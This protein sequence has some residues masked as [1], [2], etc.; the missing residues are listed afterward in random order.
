MVHAVELGGSNISAYTKLKLRTKICGR[1]LMR[2]SVVIV[3]VLA[4]LSLAVMMSLIVSINVIKTEIEVC[5]F[6]QEKTTT[7]TPQPT[8]TARQP[9]TSTTAQSTVDSTTKAHGPYKKPQSTTE[10]EH[11]TGQTQQPT[12]TTARM[13][14]TEAA[15]AKEPTTLKNDHS[16]SKTLTTSGSRKKSKREQTNVSYCMSYH[17]ICNKTVHFEGHKNCD[18]LLPGFEEIYN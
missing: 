15:T 4:F 1:T 7:H 12:Q 3:A 8:Q 9:P 11:T 10:G 13:K 6:Q 5:K 2:H 14:S 17:Q 18:V 16:E